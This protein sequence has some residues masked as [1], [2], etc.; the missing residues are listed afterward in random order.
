ML[1]SGLY[2]GYG[3][4]VKEMVENLKTRQR[5]AEGAYKHVGSAGR[6][7]EAGYTDV[8]VIVDGLKGWRAAG[9]PVG[10]TL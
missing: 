8:G 9:Q 1:V 6:A 4:P 5:A 7:V 2:Y 3:H 10:G